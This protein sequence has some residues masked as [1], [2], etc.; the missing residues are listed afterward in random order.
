MGIFVN[1][2]KVLEHCDSIPINSID[3]KRLWTQDLKM[4]MKHAFGTLDCY[5]W[6][7]LPSTNINDSYQCNVLSCHKMSFI[8]QYLALLSLLLTWCV[9]WCPV[10]LRNVVVGRLNDNYSDPDDTVMT[11]AINSSERIRM[12]PTIRLLKLS[13]LSL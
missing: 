13:T 2:S 12:A 4:R 8:L 9:Q 5:V 11:S 6:K 3:L 10:V 7:L 1:S